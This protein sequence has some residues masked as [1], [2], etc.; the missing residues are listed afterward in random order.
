VEK[1]NTE[2]KITSQ[3]EMLGNR[4]KKRLQHLSKWARRSGVNAF[5]LY[6]RDIPEIPLVLDLYGDVVSGA[7]YKRPYEKDFADE[8]KWLEAMGGAIAQALALELENII[9]KL[10]E[11]H[12]HNSGPQSCGQ[13]QYE[14]IAERGLVR[15]A[16]EGGLRFKVN[17]SDYL[18]TGLFLDRRAVR[19][20][21]RADSAGKRVLNLFCYTG[22]FSVYAADGGAASTDS[23]DLSNTYIGW[24]K[25]NFSLNGIDSQIL[26][27]EE[28][29]PRIQPG[30]STRRD[31][32]QQ[33]PTPHILIRADTVEFLHL[34]AAAR[35]SWDIIV[36]DPP[37]FSNS[38]MAADFDL[39]RDHVKM[40]GSC[41]SLL[42]PGGRLW[43]SA[44]SRSFK[45]GA[46]E[47]KASLS[48]SFP[49]IAVTDF[50]SK[51]VDEDFRGRKTPKTYILTVSETNL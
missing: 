32:N 45:T 22:S 9:I 36:I 8:E 11:K 7:L 15:E 34:A 33:S 27:L 19:R 51:A 10:R 38:S 47:L 40:L 23:V 31:P 28:Y 21:I 26:R 13:G 50:S 12:S 44:G 5:R 42:S 6:D 35:L 4:L 3:A 46:A 2:A 29:F 30:G 37:V 24:A 39:Q 49:G 14:K 43:F 20:M 41:L 18:D 48:G 1:D 17:L 16:R 25:E